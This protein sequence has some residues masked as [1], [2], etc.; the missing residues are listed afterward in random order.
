MD[1]TLTDLLKALLGDSP[2]GTF[3]RVPTQQY[4][5][6][7]SFV[8]AHGPLLYNACAGDVTQQGVGIT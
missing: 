8:S 5:G 4:C 1:N 3:Q 6:S 2:V 7:V